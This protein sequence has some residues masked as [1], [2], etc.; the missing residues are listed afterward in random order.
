[1]IHSEGV[2]EEICKKD[3]MRLHELSR[4]SERDCQ[5]MFSTKRKK[6]KN[7]IKIKITKIGKNVMSITQFS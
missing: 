2:P 6:K 3:R 4:L 5:S 7:Q 1:M